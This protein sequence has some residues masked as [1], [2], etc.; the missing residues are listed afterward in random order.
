MSKFKYSIIITGGT[1]GMG[2]EA[3]TQMA[4]DCPDH[5][6]VITSRSSNDDA[7]GAINKSLNQ[8]NT[9][10][11]PIDL[12]SPS[13]VRRF[14]R[15]WIADETKPP[16]KALVFNAALQFPYSLTLTPD[17]RME[18][19]FAIAHAGHAL[20]FHLL[21]PKLV[22]RGA[23]VVLTSSGAHDPAQKSGMPDAVYTTA[24]EVAYPPPERAALPGR[25]H[26]T[27]AKLCNLLWA[28]ALA[29]HLGDVVPERGVT[30]TTMDPG[31]MPGTGLAREASGL[32]RWLWVS[33]L[34]RLIGL[35]RIVLFPNVHTTQES[36]RNLARLAVGADVEG[37]TGKY[38]EGRKE[39]M[40]S[41]DSYSEK[42]QEDLWDWTVNFV[43][44]GDKSE[45]E[46]LN[47]FR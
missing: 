10:F 40:S 39:I 5:L 44:R 37:V 46:R 42:F 1:A 9:Q 34:P 31:L 32:E 7:A 26:Y 3:A 2:F 11:L 17:D 15:D 33:V 25:A 12:A 29:R 38:F 43:A 8:S 36:G 19:T 13:D 30:V 41:K 23:R 4:K 27:T 14:A 21:F 24:E 35:L 6:I 18:K 20:L 45:V 28:Y 22:P 47:A 16:I